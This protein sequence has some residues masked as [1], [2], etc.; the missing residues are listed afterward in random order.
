LPAGIPKPS[1]KSEQVAGWLAG[2]LLANA[3]SISFVVELPPREYSRV[4]SLHSCRLFG[5]K[6]HFASVDKFR[7]LLHYASCLLCKL[8]LQETSS[9]H[10][11]LKLNF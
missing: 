3:N 6:F 10:W 8:L 1:R 11:K 7:S 4:I 2:S 9:G 5:M